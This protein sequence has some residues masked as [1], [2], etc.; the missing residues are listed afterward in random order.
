MTKTQIQLP[1]DLY[2]RAKKL[3]EARELS[4]AEL[5]RRGLEYILS[6]YTTPEDSRTDWEPPEPRRLGWRGLTPAQLKEQAQ[7][8]SCEERLQGR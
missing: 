3:A 7:R 8:T 1:D 6:T 2:R 5:L 4:L